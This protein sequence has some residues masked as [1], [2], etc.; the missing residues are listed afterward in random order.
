MYIALHLTPR[1]VGVDHNPQLMPKL[2]LSPLLKVTARLLDLHDSRRASGESPQYQSEE[3]TGLGDGRY[4]AIAQEVLDVLQGFGVRSGEE[5]SSLPSIQQEVQARI[6]WATDLDI[7][8]VLNVLAR[9]TELRLLH[10]EDGA[11]AHVIGDKETSL[12]EKAAHVVEFRLSRVGKTALAIASDNMDIAYIEGDVTKLIRALE[13]GRLPAALGFVDRLLMQLR[14]EQLSLVALIEQTS[15]GRKSR[16]DAIAELEFHRQIMSRT[17]ELVDDARVKVDEIIRKEL[18]LDEDV[19]IGLIKAKL[20]ELSGGVVRY[21]RELSRLAEISM[22]SAQSSVQAPSFRDLAQQ[23]VKTPP[24]SQ[25][26]DL[27]LSIVG[28]AVASGIQPTGTDFAGLVKARIQQAVLVQNI[29]LDEFEIPPED[30]FLEWLSHNQSALEKR[31]Q[32]GGLDLFELLREGLG[33]MDRN[34]A[35]NCLVTALTAPDEWVNE[36]VAANLDRSL[37]RSHVPGLDALTSGMTLKPASNEG[38]KESH[39]TL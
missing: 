3:R 22:Y 14:T 37:A 23:W 38:R 39:D 4:V 19:P 9:P 29:A 36:P 18:Q 34:A 28:P 26:L 21:G 25:Q 24:A 2:D 6:V 8:Y 1:P 27:V 17:I 16:P 5:Y 31:L 11:P 30:R 33:E 32:N 10:N 20:K 7:E 15:G 35:L 12:V 13:A